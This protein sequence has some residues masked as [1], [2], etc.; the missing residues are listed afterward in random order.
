MQGVQIILALV[1][2]LLTRLRCLHSHDF[3]PAREGRRAYLVCLRCGQ[4]TPGFEVEGGYH[5]RSPRS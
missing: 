1:G 5:P 3:L 2:G 4:E